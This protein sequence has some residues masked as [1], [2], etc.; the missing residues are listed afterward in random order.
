MYDR[1]GAVLFILT[2]SPVHWGTGVSLGAVDLPVQRER[3]TGY[4]M[5]QSAGI[6]GALRDLFER[7]MKEVVDDLF[8]PE[9]K[10][11]EEPRSMGRASFGDGRVLLF[12]V[13]SGKGAFAWVTCPHVLSRL[14]AD[15]SRAGFEGYPDTIP[16]PAAGR[17]WTTEQGVKELDLA[18][19]KALL[20]DRAY[21]LEKDG[22]VTAWSNWLMESKAIP[23]DLKFH[24]DLLLKGLAVIPDDDFKSFVLQST[25]VETH[26][27]IE[28][29]TRTAKE[30]ALFQVEFV[31]SDALF[32]SVVLISGL[33]G[34]DGKKSLEDLKDGISKAGGR[35]QM[36]ADAS[37]GRGWMALSFVRG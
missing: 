28:N 23:D 36:G 20:E 8:G 3:H 2:E 1:K 35:W 26:V 12:P 6:K 9:P 7:H 31:P 32:Y 11:G 15:L 27:S 33:G 22:R 16:A 19:G 5:A 14:R 18:Q 21:A 4:P 24:R 13:R 29:E 25:V 10:S 17:A 37:T 30:G 34:K